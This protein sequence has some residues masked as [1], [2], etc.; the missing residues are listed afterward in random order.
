MATFIPLRWAVSSGSTVFSDDFARSDSPTIGNGWNE[1]E[2]GGTWAISSNKAVCTFTGSGGKEMYNAWSAATPDTVSVKLRMN[3][4]GGDGIQFRLYT[5]AS[6]GGY[7]IFIKLEKDEAFYYDGAWKSIK[8]S[9]SNNTE[10]LFEFKNVNWTAYTYDI[11]VDG[12]L[13]VSSAGFGSSKP[14]CERC[15]LIIDSAATST[16]A[17]VDDVSLTTA[18]ASTP[19]PLLMASAQGAYI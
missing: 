7:T 9:L 2:T 11:Y 17:A 3:T 13:E 1:T 18:G 5:T 4:A 8:A 14:N 6:G 12:G 15:Y 10:Y 16:D 19:G